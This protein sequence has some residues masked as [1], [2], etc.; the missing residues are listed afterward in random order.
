MTQTTSNRPSQG[1]RPTTRE[2]RR[3]SFRKIERLEAAATHSPAS[4]QARTIAHLVNFFGGQQ[5]FVRLTGFSLRSIA[6]YKAGARLIRPGNERRIHELQRLQQGLAAIMRPHAVAGWLQRPNPAL[7]NLKPLEAIE[8][9]DIDQIW[10]LIYLSESG[11][12][13]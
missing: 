8:R 13:S 3:A 4:D 9:G 11:G 10:R 6:N 1:N 7:N 2:R 12:V 5:T